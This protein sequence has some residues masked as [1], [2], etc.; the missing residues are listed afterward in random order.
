MERCGFFLQVMCNRDQALQV[1]TLNCLNS[2]LRSH[3][4]P[5]EMAGYYPRATVVKM[6]GYYLKGLFDYDCTADDSPPPVLMDW[7][8]TSGEGTTYAT[9]LR[10]CFDEEG[11]KGLVGHLDRWKDESM[12]RAAELVVAWHPEGGGQQV[13]WDLQDVLQPPWWPSTRRAKTRRQRLL[14]AVSALGIGR[15]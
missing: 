12:E 5:D 10:E 9:I 14:D 2:N 4:P 8:E 6:V 13:I 11:L 1:V 3:L 15:S 7:L